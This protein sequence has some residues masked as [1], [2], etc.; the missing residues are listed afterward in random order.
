MFN[1]RTF[2]QS[3][4]YLSMSNFRYRLILLACFIP[5]FTLA[6]SPAELKKMGDDYFKAG[7]YQDAVINYSQYQL[8][9]PGDMSVITNLGISYFEVRDFTKASEY[10]QYVLSSSARSAD[11]IVFYYQAKSY[12]LLEKWSEAIKYYKLFL[13]VANGKHALRLS[14]IDEIKRCAFAKELP[15]NPTLS[16]VQNLGS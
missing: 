14:A 12:H 8:E 3:T 15:N 2:I 11:P 5:F 16:L 10:F 13:G 6:Q 1:K 4:S 9:K 7:K